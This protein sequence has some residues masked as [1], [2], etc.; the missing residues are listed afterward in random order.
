VKT[1]CINVTGEVLGACFY[2]LAVVELG[3]IGM[4][5]S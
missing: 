2:Q 3:R 1:G 4:L 5:I